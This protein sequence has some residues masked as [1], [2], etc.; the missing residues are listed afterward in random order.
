MTEIELYVNKTIEQNAALYYEKGKKYKKKIEGINAIIKKT[1]LK[2]ENAEKKAEK[3]E[4]ELIQ[5]QKEEEVLI[6]RKKQKKWYERYRWFRSSD[7]FLVI[8][9]RDATTNE[10]IIKKYT[11]KDDLVLHTDMS[12]SPFFVI[13]SEGKKIPNSTIKEAA[14]AVCTFSRAWKLGLY[15]QQVFYVKPEQVTK[16]AQSGE[17]LS[18]G[19]FMIRG[20]TKYM[21]NEINCAIGMTK[22]GQIMSGPIEAVKKHCKKYLRV[23]RGRLKPSD[24]AKKIKKQIG[25]ELDEIIRALPSGEMKIV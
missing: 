21:D 25:G 3:E 18:K 11:D 20:R 5:K 15:S 1:K 12:G 13:K 23:E 22:E 8:G 16:T 10:V 14:D 24:A 9:G 19:A 6:E 7:G 2:L 17:Y 4:K